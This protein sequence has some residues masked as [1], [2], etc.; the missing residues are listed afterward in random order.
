MILLF[1]IKTWERLPEWLRHTT[2]G[3][4]WFWIGWQSGEIEAVKLC[5]II[6]CIAEF[7]DEIEFITKPAC[8]PEG[9]SWIDL[10]FRTLPAWLYLIAWCLLNLK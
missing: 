8:H 9:F 7:R 2:E 3:A 1:L 5:I 4:L 6:A 10:L